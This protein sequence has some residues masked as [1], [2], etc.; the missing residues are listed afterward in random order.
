[1]GSLG[2]AALILLLVTVATVSAL[3]G[4]LAATKS[5]RRARLPFI[6]GFLCGMLA[7]GILRG[8]R[9]ALTMAARAATCAVV[10]MPGGAWS[11]L[12]PIRLRV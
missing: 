3:G 1:M 7:F 9:H 6:A 10:R 4:F 8:R 2:T 12:R 11:S 5:R